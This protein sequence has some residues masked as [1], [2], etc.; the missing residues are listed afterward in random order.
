MKVELKLTKK[1]P[2]SSLNLNN[3]KEYCKYLYTDTGEVKRFG[4]AMRVAIPSKEKPP[5]VFK[6]EIKANIKK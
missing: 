6:L 2:I 5:K 3:G 1:K 4:F